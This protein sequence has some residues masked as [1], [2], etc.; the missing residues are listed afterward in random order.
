MIALSIRQPWAWLITRPDVV[1]AAARAALVE[2]DLIKTVENR[3]WPTNYRGQM[4]L[5]AGK[6]CTVADYDAALLF[7]EA[8]VSPAL[9]LQV[10]D[11]A[12]LPRGGVVGM[13]HLVD[14]VRSHP[15]RFFTGDPDL[16]EGGY[17]FVLQGSIAVPFLPW[18]GR[19]GF[20]DVVVKR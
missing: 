15:S 20:F 16:P 6:T 18:K 10:P 1:G 17:G 7:V 19:L 11:L 8:F 5:H 12:E 14:C 9:A 13:T 4:L 3:D 2:Q